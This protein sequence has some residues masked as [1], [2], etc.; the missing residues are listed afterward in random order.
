MKVNTAQIIHTG[1]SGVDKSHI[2]VLLLSSGQP[3]TNPRL[4]KE[5]DALIA[6]GY[7]VKVYYSYWAHWAV[8]KD[9]E[10]VKGYPDN[11]FEMVGGSPERKALTYFF[12][13]IIHYFGKKIN[14]DYWKIRAVSR[15]THHLVR[16]AKNYKA[17]IY[18]AHNLGALPAAVMAAKKFEAVCGF[19]AEDYHSGEFAKPY[20]S[21]YK[22]VRWVEEN[23]LPRC[24]YLTASS[25]LIALAYQKLLSVNLPVVLNVFSKKYLST[26]LKKQSGSLSVFWFSQTIGPNRGLEFFIDALNDLKEKNISL[27]LMGDCNAG[28]RQELINR[29]NKKEALHILEP[30]GPSDIFKIASQY[31]IGLA[32]EIPY[33][34]NRDYC[35]TNKIFTY[36][37]AGNF[38]LASDTTAQKA[39]IYENKQI[40]ELYAHDNLKSLTTILNRLYTDENYMMNCRLKALELASKEMNWENQSELFLN[41]VN[42][43]MRSKPFIN[44]QF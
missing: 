35:L 33:S 41:A 34:E 32:S 38:I 20:D 40:G 26:Q 1:N 12:S 2:R 4:V 36:L 29:I 43:S 19:D 8:E 23:F 44:R 30:A 9:V 22:V 25:P 28:Y 31:D 3:T 18:I 27:Y 7:Q 21:A 11:V 16:A 13:R 14:R 10:L 15:A 24:N 5:A 42:E 17:D 37:L 39:F 6:N